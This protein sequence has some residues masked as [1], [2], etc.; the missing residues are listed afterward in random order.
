[1]SEEE[2]AKKPITEIEFINALKIVKQYKAQVNDTIVEALGDKLKTRVED[3]I[4]MV[5]NN[6]G[7][8]SVRLKN[9][10][11]MQNKIKYIEDFNMHNFLLIPSAGKK[12]WR[13]LC[14]LTGKTLKEEE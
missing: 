2:E 7:D 8:I 11:R 3:F 12:T 14:E 10:L 4:S 9:V 5:E 13:E 1:M 6:G